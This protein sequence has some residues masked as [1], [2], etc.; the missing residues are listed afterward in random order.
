VN[1]SIGQG[2][3]LTTP[4]QVIRGY[5]TIQNGGTL[6][7]PHVGLDV[8]DQ[9]G[10]LV[11]E[12]SPKPAGKVNVSQQSLQTTIEGLRKVT[13]PGGTAENIFK[14]SKLQVV[15]KSGTGEVWGSDW[16]NW[17]VGWAENQERPIIVLVMVEGGGAF[18]QGSEVTAG[19]A[20]R[21]VLE[22]FYGVEPTPENAAE[23]AAED[24][25]AEAPAD[26]ALPTVPQPAVPAAPVGAIYSGTPGYYAPPTY[27]D[28]NYQAPAY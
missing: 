14:G 24:E 3:L 21:H 2:D 7:T 11:E 25:P 28:P 22:S 4:L 16:V 23:P 19:P 5:A 13:G 26:G 1:M 17:F 12:I 20:A 6:V 27:S 9:N 15:G 18:E 10:D 8:R